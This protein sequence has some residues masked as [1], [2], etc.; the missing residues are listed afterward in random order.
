[1]DYKKEMNYIIIINLITYNYYYKN[2]NLKNYKFISSKRYFEKY[3]YY[4]L[5][6]HVVYE[7]F[8]DASW[9]KAIA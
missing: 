5:A 1:M 6:D 3:L 8:I 9:G 4:K 7:K 2:C